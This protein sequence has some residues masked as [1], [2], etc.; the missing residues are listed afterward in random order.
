MPHLHT[1]PGQHDFTVSAFIIRTDGP[2]P[3]VIL[4]L[5]RKIGVLLQFGG[6]IELDETPWQGLL[7]ELREESG[8]DPAQLNLLQPSSFYHAQF[9]GSR[10]HP[11]PFYFNTHEFRPGN[12]HF[13]SDL[14]YAA[15]VTGA[16]KHSIREGESEAI[17]AFTASALKRLPP[18][19]IFEQTRANA[20]YILENLLLDWQLLP[21]SNWPA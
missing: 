18:E 7:R 20:V 21:A 4:H 10:Q 9:P 14:T 17:R 16:P 11:L 2:E 12:G 8:Y 5:H 13:H 3:V 15:V 1:S 6:H 19:E